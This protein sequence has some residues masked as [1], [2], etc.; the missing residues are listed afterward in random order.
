[1]VGNQISK[2][3]KEAGMNQYDLA[4]NLNL[5]PSAIG[6]YEQNR[7]TP[8]I[9]VLVLIA[10]Y[11]DVSLDYLITGTEYIPS[12]RRSDNMKRRIPENCPCRSCYWKS[13]L[14]EMV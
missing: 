1:M 12:V 9:Q 13:Y 3:R 7:R 5:S 4:E 14:E 6:M 11:F 2:L 8:S 10:D